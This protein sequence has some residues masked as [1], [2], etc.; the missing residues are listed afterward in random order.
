MLFALILVAMRAAV[1]EVPTET[2]EY[3]ASWDCK[4]QVEVWCTADSCAASAPGEFTP[5]SVSVKA[6]GAISACAYTGCWEGAGAMTRSSGRALWIGDG[7]KFSTQ[8]DSEGNDVTVLIIE[9]EGVG[10][11]RVGGLATPLLCERS[12]AAPL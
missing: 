2:P 11:V 12:I 9:H 7:L 10:F 4:N 6:D 3:Q 1:S 8:P 5:M